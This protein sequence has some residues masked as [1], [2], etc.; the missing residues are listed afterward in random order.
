MDLNR[1]HRALE[2]RRMEM[3]EARR[4]RFLEGKIKGKDIDADEWALIVAMDEWERDE[5]IG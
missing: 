1:L 2:A 5:S 4:R 3:V